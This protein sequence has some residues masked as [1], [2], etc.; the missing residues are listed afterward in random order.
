[1]AGWRL[2]RRTA[3]DV[4][5]S[6]GPSFVN[7]L[8]G[9]VVSALSHKP[10]VC[11]FR[12]AWMADPMLRTTTPRRLLQIHARQEAFVIN[13]SS[14]V[15]TTNPF[16][17]ADFRNRYVS[18]SRIY[19]TIYNGFDPDD[20]SGVTPAPTTEGRLRVVHT[21]RLYG[22]RS[23]RPLLQAVRALFESEPALRGKVEVVLVG[24]CEVFDD[25]KQV[26]DYI[27]EMGLE[28]AVRVTGYVSRQESLAHQAGADV[29]VCVTGRVPEQGRYTYGIA[30]KLFDYLPWH[31]PILA[32]TDEGATAAFLR[33]HGIGCVF[34]PDD[35]VGQTGYLAKLCHEKDAMRGK[36]GAA[37]ALSDKFNTRTLTGQL[38]ECF[39]DVSDVKR[40]ISN[41]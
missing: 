30:G 32:L 39:R 3:V 27:R 40:E 28:A 38:A 16:V 33:E 1:M 19:Q 18:S 13:Q 25:G 21:G 9:A 15:I 5:Y 17:T 8:V 41:G 37:A 36:H 12:D 22:E 23:P 10:L 31:K 11:D 20:Y 35:I 14:A 26:E 24:A 34:S 4:I 29:L 2:T 6:S 7:H